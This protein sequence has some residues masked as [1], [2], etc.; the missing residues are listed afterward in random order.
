MDPINS[1]PFYGDSFTLM[2]FLRVIPENELEPGRFCEVRS[3][4]GTD[5][6]CDI[7]PLSFSGMLDEA[8]L[9]SFLTRSRWSSEMKALLT[10]DGVHYG[11]NSFAP[12][13]HFS[14]LRPASLF[15]A[16]RYHTFA[17]HLLFDL[18]QCPR[19]SGDN[20]RGD[21]LPTYRTT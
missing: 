1:S 20:I 9:I 17:S 11:P 14:F 3:N 12:K 7:S 16:S 19:R 2:K 15:Y 13:I 8:Y 18:H 5:P 6:A 4:I 21:L 10:A